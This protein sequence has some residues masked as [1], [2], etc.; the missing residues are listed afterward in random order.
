[1]A[2]GE[3]AVRPTDVG[4]PLCVRVGWS[5]GGGHFFAVTGYHSDSN[6]WVSVDDPIYGPSDVTFAALQSA[7][8]ATGTWTHSYFTNPSDRSWQSAILRSAERA[9]L[10]FDAIRITRPHQVHVL[11]LDDLQRGAPISAARPVAWR[12]PVEHDGAPVS[13]ADVVTLPDGSHQVA[14]LNYG[15]F[16]GG[17]ARAFARVESRDEAVD[18]GLLHVPALHVVALWIDPGA[19]GRLV[20]CAPAPPFLEEGRGYSADEFVSILRDQARAIDASADDTGT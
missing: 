8:Q 13:L 19:C 3:L 18:V 4:R 17:T 9:A 7:V 14:Q 11:G 15:P 10:D 6:D 20:P 1:V 5:G 2:V 12:H 16:V